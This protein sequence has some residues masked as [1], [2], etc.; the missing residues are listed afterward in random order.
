MW[1]MTENGTSERP[2]A[3]MPTVIRWCEA[4]RVP[5]VA[6]WPQRCRI[7]WD[8]IAKEELCELCGKILLEMKSFKYQV[9]ENINERKPW[10]W[11]WRKLSS[12]SLF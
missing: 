6:T 9:G 2:I 3:L 12:G 10:S 5:E 8:D 11:T 1:E 7:D 4:M